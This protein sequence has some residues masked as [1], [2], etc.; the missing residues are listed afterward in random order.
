MATEAAESSIAVTMTVTEVHRFTIDANWFADD[1]DPATCTPEQLWEAVRQHNELYP[2]DL[3]NWVDGEADESRVELRR[4][5]TG[6]TLDDSER[7][8]PDV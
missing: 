8:Q 2:A 7:R 1:V 6:E 5:D 3:W 4:D